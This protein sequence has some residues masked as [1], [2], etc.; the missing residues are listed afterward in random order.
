ME[1]FYYYNLHLTQPE[2]NNRVDY[3]W[4]VEIWPL[5]WAPLTVNFQLT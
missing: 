5:Q 1:L 4:R 2:A 3:E